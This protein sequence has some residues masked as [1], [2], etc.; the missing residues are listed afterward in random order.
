MSVDG[1]VDA[2]QAAWCGRDRDAF[3][4]V[5][6]PDLHYED[7]VTD[8]ALHGPGE[9]AEHVAHLWSGLPDARM[10]TTGAR[11]TDGRFVVAPCK[12]LGTHREDLGGLPASGR[13]VV[14]HA[15]FYCELDSGRT[16]LWRVRGFFD[17]YDAAVQLGVLPRP[18]TLSERALMVM[19]GFGVRGIR[20][21]D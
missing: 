10:E 4:A 12:L 15:V 17:A 11:L 18:G 20:R 8:V 3:A 7:P 9:L 16:H 21:R 2:W 5:C 1:L 14:V 13:F 6:A 19:R